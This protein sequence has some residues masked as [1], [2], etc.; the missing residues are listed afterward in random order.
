MRNADKKL[1]LQHSS[2]RIQHLFVALRRLVEPR[3]YLAP[4]GGLPLARY[5]AAAVGVDSSAI[6]I[7]IIS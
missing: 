3:G 6:R 2:F 4:C 5:F 1:F 7:A